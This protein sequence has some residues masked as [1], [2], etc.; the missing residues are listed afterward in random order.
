MH[1]IQYVQ[2]CK[3]IPYNIV[4]ENYSQEVIFE[5]IPIQKQTVIDIINCG[6][7]EL[8]IGQYPKKIL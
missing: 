2:I 7:W 8:P 4:C 5:R 6:L 1:D 3:Q